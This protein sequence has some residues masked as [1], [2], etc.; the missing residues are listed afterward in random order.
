MQDIVNYFNKGEIK[1][2]IKSEEIKDKYYNYFYNK[3]VPG[4][5]CKEIY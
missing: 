5:A 1:K 2:E 3:L 4:G